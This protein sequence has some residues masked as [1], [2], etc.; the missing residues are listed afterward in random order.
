MSQNVNTVCK[1][2]YYVIEEKVS[3]CQISCNTSTVSCVTTDCNPYTDKLAKV[4][5]NYRTAR[6]VT[7]MLKTIHALT[8][9]DIMD[10]TEN[11]LVVIP[12]AQER[13]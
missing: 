2:D 6:L 13:T 4:V 1:A 8:C 9:T 7:D 5:R 3:E 12:A 11:I 10:R